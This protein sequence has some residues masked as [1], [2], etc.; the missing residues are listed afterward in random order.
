MRINSSLCALTCWNVDG[1]KNKINNDFFQTKVSQ[2]DIIGLVETWATEESQCADLVNSSLAN[3]NYVFV[4]AVGECTVG[5]KSGGI[6]LLYRKSISHAIKLVSKNQNIIWVQ[7]SAEYFGWDKDM[8]LATVHIPPSNSKYYTNQYSALETDI[9]NMS[10]LGDVKLMGDFNARLGNLQ[11]YILGDSDK[12]LNLPSDYQSDTQI[13]RHNVDTKINAHGKNLSSLC[14]TTQLR[15]L[16]GRAV[17]DTLGNYTYHDSRGSS[18]IDLFICSEA[19][20]NKIWGMQ[21]HSI[22]HLSRHC[23]ISCYL[24]CQTAPTTRI[25]KGPKGPKAHLYTN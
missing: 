16:N 11:D 24:K 13:A 2:Y 18:A 3:F 21:I 7:L 22:N 19:I 12:Y 25:I 6:I 8:F 4:P 9:A 17:G 5:R 15:I 20:L 10:N 1:I 23:Q 14:I